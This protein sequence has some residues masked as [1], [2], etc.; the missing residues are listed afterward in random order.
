MARFE[1]STWYPCDGL[2]FDRDEVAFSA[3]GRESDDSGW[4]CGEREHSWTCKTKSTAEKMK[5]ALEGA[6]F[7]VHVM[8]Y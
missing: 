5:R 2:S 1:V 7:D 3:A 6:G 8:E 4:G